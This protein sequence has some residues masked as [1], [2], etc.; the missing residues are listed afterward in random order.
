M[1]THTRQTSES[2][3]VTTHIHLSLEICPT[4]GQEIPADKIEEIGGR[5]AARE[6]EQALAITLQLEKQYAIEKAA[7]E[8]K[9]KADL[10]SAREQSSLREERA[11]EEAQKAAEKL[12]N[13]RQ[14]EAE[15]ARRGLV[16]GW[17][18][19]LAEAE[20][21]RKSA[22]QT[23]GSL[24]AE[25]QLLR[26]TNAQALEA[27]KAQ[28]QQRETEVRN[29]AIR[30][31]ES[32]MAERVQAAETARRQSEEALQ[33]KINEVEASRIAAQEN[34]AALQLQIGKMKEDAATEMERVRQIATE[35]AELRLRDTLA[36]HEKAV[37]EANART[38][39][40]EK[41]AS[42]LQ[43]DL[44]AQREIMEQA[45]DEAINAERAKAFEETQKLSNKVNDLQRALERKSNEELGE[46]AEVKVFE[47][48]K[49]EFKDDR[50]ERIPK[51]VEGADIRHVVM[52]NGQKCGTILYDSK[53]HKQW[54]DEHAAKLRKDQLAE[55][56]E[57]AILSTHKFP[58]DTRQLHL[59]DGVLLANPARVVAVVTIIRKHLLQLHT[60]RV[61]KVQRERKT[62]ALYEF[63]ISER[64][65][66]LLDRVDQRAS[67]LLDLQEKDIKWHQ[68][69]WEH[70]GTAIRAIQ[71]AKVD[72]TG[73]INAILG[74]AESERQKRE[75][76]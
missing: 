12:I 56:A 48:L 60:L 13:D 33:A 64:C 4:C 67:A 8:A 59:R 22:E 62:A 65:K 76:S 63:I 11:R 2:T 3:D 58:R 51:G 42:E 35:R 7:R 45:K 46:G 74:T 15:Q 1:T 25:M 55:K 30:D 57:H 38:H 10:E 75:A 39:E 54:R 41:H 68:K 40:A 5:I 16:A 9:A 31:S 36:A 53:N 61:S 6:R 34:E 27:V 44:R 72:L 26:D 28:A 47:A 23:E 18:K 71:K 37:G 29:E 17:E 14:A 49:K 24:Q 73:E 66:Q 19:K 32:A 70:Q 52:L 21:A 69:N 50:I 20:S 43:Q